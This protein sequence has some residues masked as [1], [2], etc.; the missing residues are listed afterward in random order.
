MLAKVCRNLV[1]SE[2]DCNI[3]TN[4]CNLSL[5]L[6]YATID[7]FPTCFVILHVHG[8]MFLDLLSRLNCNLFIIMLVFY[9]CLLVSGA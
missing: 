8:L 2:E 5:I 7:W 9:C 1:L 4:G 6:I 3:K